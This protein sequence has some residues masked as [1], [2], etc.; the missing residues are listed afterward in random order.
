MDISELNDMREY[1][2]IFKK[3]FGLNFDYGFTG[4]CCHVRIIQEGPT[5]NFVF[6]EAYRDTFKKCVEYIQERIY[7][8][9]MTPDNPLFE[10]PPFSSPKELEMKLT[11]MGK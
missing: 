5:Y 3:F 4:T 2:D 9:R 1:H 10:I 8:R 11:L 6:A 7:T